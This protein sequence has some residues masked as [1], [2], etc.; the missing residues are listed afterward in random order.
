[1]SIGPNFSLR[2]TP[3][4]GPARQDQVNFEWPTLDQLKKL[5]EDVSLK[6]I[7]FKADSGYFN[8]AFAQCILSDNTSS[9]VIGNA[10]N[11]FYKQD[12]QIFNFV[13]NRVRSVQAHSDDMGVQSLIF[14][15]AMDKKISGYS[16]LD[17]NYR[18]NLVRHLI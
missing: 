4:W 15:D 7:E 12:A 14:Y 10:S 1:M 18:K 6:S 13:G 2:K 8:I 9:P 17:I 5:P 11:Q 3:I 16:P